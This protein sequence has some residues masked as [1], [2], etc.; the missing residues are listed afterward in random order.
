MNQEGIVYTLYDDLDDEYL[1]NLAKKGIKPEYYEI[2]N[3]ELVPYKGRNTRKEK[4]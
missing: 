3:K 4:N 2:K 1:N